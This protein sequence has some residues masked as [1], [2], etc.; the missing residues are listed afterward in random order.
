MAIGKAPN[1][2]S[3]CLSLEERRGG[4]IGFRWNCSRAEQ[5]LTEKSE[6]MEN[7]SGMSRKSLNSLKIRQC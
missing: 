5:G 6:E 3:P 1:N 7:A 2:C 4:W